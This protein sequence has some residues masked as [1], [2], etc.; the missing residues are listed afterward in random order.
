M[1]FMKGVPQIYQINP[2]FQ[3]DCNFF[4][5]LP[6][7]APFTLRVENSPF[8]I[9][10]VLMYN[11]SLDSLITFLH[12]LAD[13]EAFLDLLNNNNHIN[14]EYGTSLGSLGFRANNAYV[15]LDI[16]TRGM[17]R[18]SY[19]DDLVKF[20]IYGP[21]SAMFYDFNGLGTNSTVW[22]E[23][24]LG[25]SYKIG[26]KFSIGWRGKI[27][28]GAADIQVKNFD[29]T[30]ATGE[31]KWDVHSDILVNAALPFL[32][33]GFD[34]EGMI[35]FENVETK[36]FPK[37]LPSVLANRNNSGLAMDVGFDFKPLNWLQLSA[38][39]ID[40]GSIN[41]KESV[42]NIKNNA[43]YSFAGLEVSISD[44][45]FLQTLADSLEQ[46]FKFSATENGYRTVLPTKLYAGFS[47]YPHPKINFGFLSRTEFL[48]G[49]IR[50][51]FTMSA[52]FY[53][54]RML[55]AAFSYSIIDGNYKNLGFGLSLKPGPF[56]FYI[57]TDTMPS[58]ALWPYEARFI[59][60]RT[61]LN[62]AFGCKKIKKE[63]KFDRAFSPY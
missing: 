56:N 49:D 14:T 30:L 40:F 27:M 28:L 24:A 2:A 5:G 47:L 19:P 57:I 23:F 6:G 31:E 54:L 11:E 18:L 4:I 34:D 32:N 43:D 51:Q 22:N 41:W 35:D 61:G 17:T 44:D 12:P 48:A 7:F 45:D 15:S 26:E 58:A 1:F 21:D 42:Y 60:I 16:N 29:V 62:L 3:P 25:F 10:D 20:P 52:N 36:E 63:P 50:Q 55:S 37:A 59:N 53:P 46:T 8:A 39:L 33:V 9:G 13:K 38:S